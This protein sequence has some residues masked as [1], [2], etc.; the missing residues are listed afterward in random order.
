VG[1]RPISGCLVPAGQQRDRLTRRLDLH[2]YP[3]R[4]LRHE[5]RA[6][7]AQLLEVLRADGVGARDPALGTAIAQELARFDAH[8]RDPMWIIGAPSTANAIP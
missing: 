4:R 6:A 1:R 3:V 7:L 8:M 5:L 2:G